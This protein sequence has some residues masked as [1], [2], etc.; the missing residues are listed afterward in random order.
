MISRF[1]GY[2]PRTAARGLARTA[3]TLLLAALLVQGCATIGS[4]PFMPPE[5]QVEAALARDDYRRALEVIDRHLPEPAELWEERRAEIAG[6][7]QADATE[8]MHTARQLSSEGE[9]AR[10]L[11]ILE[12]ADTRLPPDSEREQF[13]EQLEH[14][15]QV[16]LET[17][18]Q[19]HAILEARAVA[20][21]M[22]VLEVMRPL[23]RSH[24]QLPADPQR[25]ARR[26][27]ALARVVDQ[28]ADETSRRER[29]ELLQLAQDLAP[30]PGRAQKIA[31]LEHNLRAGVDANGVSRAEKEAAINSRLRQALDDGD[32]HKAARWCQ[33]EVTIDSRASGPDQAAQRGRQALCEEWRQKRDRY[34][35][36]RLEEGRGYYTAGR[37]EDALATWEQGLEL[38]PDHSGLM[39]ARER[40]LRVIERLET[41]R[42]PEGGS[43][44]EAAGS[45][46]END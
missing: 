33:D 31:R 22:R 36:A 12:D 35:E 10:A 23:V 37:I 28:H 6:K 1:T 21:Q 32:L 13:M 40:A 16:G 43:G 8:A 26:A 15:R 41:L 14:Q 25:V 11:E 44:E 38:A 34:A 7:A 2:C 46:H 4:L 24:D 5:Q 20:Q 3:P 29:L 45:A 27:E 9:V 18:S 39:A 42:L 30:D 17:M 19:R